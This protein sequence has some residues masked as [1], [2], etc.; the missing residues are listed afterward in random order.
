MQPRTEFRELSGHFFQKLTF[1]HRI[2]PGFKGKEVGYS[3]LT[4]LW[5]QQP[6]APRET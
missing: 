1:T 6:R 2:S 5:R 4:D 3:G